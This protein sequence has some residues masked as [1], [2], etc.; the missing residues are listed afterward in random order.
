M[1]HPVEVIALVATVGPMRVGWTLAAVAC[2]AGGMAAALACSG[3]TGGSN[4]STDAS[5]DQSV[6]EASTTDQSAFDSSG[7][8]DSGGHSGEDAGEEA[9]QDAGCAP[10][11]VDAAFVFTPPNAPRNVCTSAQIHEFYVDCWS[12]TQTTAACNAFYGEPA[13]SS[14]ILCMVSKSTASTWA[15]VVEFPNDITSA[16]ISGC[17]AIVTGDAGPGSCAYASQ[18]LKECVWDSCEAHCPTGAT[19][20][21][22]NAYEQC[23]TA[24]EGSVCATQNQ[25]AACQ[26]AYS[27]CQYASFE[28]YFLGIGAFFCSAAADGG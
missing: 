3:K 22:V 26:S 21:G 12:T 28:A 6:I 25:A 13:N 14:C 1:R 2:V 10:E 5:A 16:N 24:A 23:V 17:I 18:A 7:N 20:A 8:V 11:P 4:S 15:A 9:G 19:S 27:A